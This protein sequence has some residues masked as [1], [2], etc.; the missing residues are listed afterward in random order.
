MK[1]S[2]K[3]LLIFILSCSATW[4]DAIA[5][6]CP[7]EPGWFQAGQS[8]YLVSIEQMSWYASQEVD[9]EREINAMLS[10]VMEDT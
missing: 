2:L 3:P 6:K 10:G 1:P 4:K 7:N 8:C 9:I 5:K